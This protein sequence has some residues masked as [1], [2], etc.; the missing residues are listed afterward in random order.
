MDLTKLGWNADLNQQFAPHHAK[1]LVP[2]RV[3]VED[4]HFFRVWTAEAELLAQVTGKCFHDARRSNSN[5]PKVGDWVAVKLVPSEEKAMIQAILPRRT[6]LCRKMI[7][8]GGTEHI[9]A[10]N[11]DTAFLLQPPF[12]GRLR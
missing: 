1:G 9:L 2:A 10:T 5:L 8:R 12:S 7:G 11:I 6:Q 3:A 4:K